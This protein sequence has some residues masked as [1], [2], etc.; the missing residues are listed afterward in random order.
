M[1]EGRAK[2]EEEPFNGK[3]QRSID[4]AGVEVQRWIKAEFEYRPGKG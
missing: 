1:N 3:V 2:R 4:V